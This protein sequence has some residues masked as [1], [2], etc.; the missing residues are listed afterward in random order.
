MNGM[1]WALGAIK[2]PKRCIIARVRTAWNLPFDK[3]VGQLPWIDQIIWFQTMLK[4]ITHSGVPN[5]SLMAGTNICRGLRSR[6]TSDQ[7]D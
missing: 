2:N 3:I 5:L 1:L 4:I 6:P 7:K